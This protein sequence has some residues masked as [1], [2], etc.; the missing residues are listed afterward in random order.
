MMPEGA[1]QELAP[2]PRAY[3][4]ATF[5]PLLVTLDSPSTTLRTGMVLARP[6]GFPNTYQPVRDL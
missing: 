4:L 6:H 2:S 1:I 5:W 3:T